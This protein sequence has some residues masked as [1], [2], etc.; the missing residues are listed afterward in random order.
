MNQA[1]RTKG[2]RGSVLP[3]VGLGLVM[4]L[5]MAAFAIDLG[6]ARQAK[7]QVQSTTDAAALAGAQSLKT[8]GN[9]PDGM[10]KAIYDA[11]DWAYRNLDMPVPAPTSC[12]TNK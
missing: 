12:G 3:L 5:V 4:M 7:A 8:T 11:A 6:S 2:D 1:S 10:A 9:G